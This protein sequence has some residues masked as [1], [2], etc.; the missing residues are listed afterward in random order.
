[1]KKEVTFEQ[2]FIIL[3]QYNGKYILV[4]KTVVK[5]SKNMTIKAYW[6]TKLFNLVSFLEQFFEAERRYI[7]DYDPN[8]NKTRFTIIETA[9]EKE[10]NKVQYTFFIYK[11]FGAFQSSLRSLNLTA[12]KVYHGYEHIEDFKSIK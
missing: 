11:N 1:M 9:L 7:I 8:P 5:N 3:N 12:Q 2:L 10:Q 6:H 4:E